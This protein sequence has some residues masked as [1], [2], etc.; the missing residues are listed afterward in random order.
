M[1]SNSNSGPF[2]YQ[3]TTSSSTSSSVSS[4]LN[5]SVAPDNTVPTEDVP[6]ALDDIREQRKKLLMMEGKII[7]KGL[8]SSDPD[9]LMK[10]TKHWEDVKR[11]QDSGIKT[12]IVDPYEFRDSLGYKDRPSGMSFHVMRNMAKTPLIRAV[13]TTRQAQVSAFSSPQTNKYDTGFVIQKK[14]KFFSTEQDEV[15]DEDREKMNVIARF[16][17]DGGE[18]GNAW[19][20]D[21]FDMFLKKIAEDSLTLDQAAFEVVRNNGGVPVEFIAA[22]GATF[23]VASTY[24]QE[25]E[26]GLMER[27]PSRGYLPKYV[28]IIDGEIDNDY[29]PW[30]LCIGIRNASTSIYE[31]GYGK[32]E[33]EALVQ[34]VTWMLYSDTYNGKF[35]SQ[36]ASPKGFLKVAGNVN[37]N[38]IQE[39][40]QQWQS[41]TAGVMNAWKVPIIE[42][43]KMEWIDLQKNNTDMQFGQWQEYL[44]KVVCA[45]YKI[46][47]EELGFDVGSAGGSSSL[48]ESGNE[49]KLKFSKDKGLKPLL[50]NIE[51]WIN[52]WIVN[53]LD[54]NFEFKFVG[55]EAEDESK[56]LENDIKRAGSFMSLKEVRR[57]NDLP[58]DIEEGDMILNP[59]WQQASAMQAM[60]GDQDQ[61]N[62]AVEQDGGG[63]WDN[64]DTPDEDMEFDNGDEETQKALYAED[65]FKYEL[66]EFVKSI[67]GE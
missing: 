56:A 25:Q 61:S 8:N 9:V 30:E 15:T 24:N 32:S 49:S 39:F 31:N 33:L 36:G 64:L 4:D 7:E 67:T 19:D 1:S 51:F 57:R 47:P 34:I 12:T 44:L 60:Q 11:R 43:E 55:L 3:Y 29:Y 28:Q 59:I 35:F 40:R 14:A 21:T 2:S 52:K 66:N 42:S 6:M 13:I 41:M 27:T 53:A 62:E 65:P 54:S 18:D 23:R 20:G 38:R 58:E 26:P 10:A 16:L 17:L 50:K 46:S 22:D 45:V 5:K 48:F 37:S 63:V